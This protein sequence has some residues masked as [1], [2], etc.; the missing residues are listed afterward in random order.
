MTRFGARHPSS[1]G[2]L[3]LALSA[4]ACG[5]GSGHP[6]SA[7]VTRT[8][9]AGIEIVS[10]ETPADAVPVFATLDSA[11][12]LRLGSADGAKEEQ[13]G[14]ITGVAPLSDGSVAVLDG[15]AAE[16]RVF[17]PNGAYLRTM[18]QKGEGP[19]ELSYP[20][21]LVALAGDTL[22]VYDRGNGRITRF[23]P[24]GEVGRVAT[25]QFDGYERP[26]FTSFFDDGSMVGYLRLERRDQRLNTSDEQT[27]VLD[28]AALT[29]S[30]TDGALED[31]IG[32]FPGFEVVSSVSRRDNNVIVQLVPAAFARALV[33]AAV[34]GGVW[35][36]FSDH[37]TLRLLDPAD[38]SVVR[39]M[40]APGLQ[41]PLTDAEANAVLDSAL[42]SAEKPEQRRT[43]QERYEAS[44]RPELR[45]A[46][47]R[48]VVDDQGH[49]WLRDWPGAH[50]DCELWWVF[51]RDGGLLGSAHAPRGLQL[52]TV[53]DG[54]AWGVVRDDLD[55][56]YVVRYGV[57]AAAA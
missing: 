54:Q 8:D 30:G 47:D 55:V 42:A 19:G 2:V 23:N 11:P 6:P 31:T 9:S 57:H 41:R 10:N 51:D 16:V 5:G 27:F 29:L 28:S 48:L 22:A 44:P 35:V 20:E 40:R 37:F 24:D 12:S 43:R 52:M 17:G 1:L 56:Q 14:S 33:F 49:L 7:R 15:Q 50:T 3:A 25:L 32:V 36:G 26:Y 13:F 34:P 38:G 39:I 53:R 21:A 4:A 46:Y 45:P 18:G